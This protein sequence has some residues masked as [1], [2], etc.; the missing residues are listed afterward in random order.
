M[1]TKIPNPKHTALSREHADPD[2]DTRPL[3]WFLIMLLGAMAM[4]GAF[5]IYSTPSGQDSAWGDQRTEAS[6][7]PAPAIADGAATKADGKQLFAT[8]CVACHQAS[9][10]GVPGVFPPLVGSEW[11]LGSEK[12][13][14]AILL[15]GVT[16]SLTVKGTS[17][18]GSM[19]AF[20]A[21]SDAELAGVMSYLRSEW[22][23]AAPAVTPEALK[24][25]RDATQERKESFKGE[26]ELKSIS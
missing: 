12:T 24:T 17:Y 3:P 18:N 20:G 25:L 1:K 23:N 15:H 21:L 19:P 11:V 5:Y 2:E 6:L 22:G 8:Q 14:G 26:A 10:L 13:L 16:G 4:W 9:G 7:R